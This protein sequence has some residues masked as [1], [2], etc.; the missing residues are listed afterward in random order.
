MKET[1]NKVKRQ[2]LEWEKIIANKTTDKELISKIY[3]QLMQFNTRKIKTPNQKVKNRPEQTFI[4]RRYT[5]ANKH[6]KRCSISHIIR[7]M[8]IKTTL[9]LVYHLILVRMAIIKMFTNNKCW[10]G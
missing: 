1:T 7:E 8:Q 2:P 9:T 3:K 4:Q 10:R 5:D 6:I